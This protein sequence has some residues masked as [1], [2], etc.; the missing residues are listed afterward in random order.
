LSL[1]TAGAM[2]TENNVTPET[3]AWLRQDGRL[4]RFE[5]NI[6]ANFSNEVMAIFPPCMTRRLRHIMSQL[7]G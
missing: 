6:G 5:A 7:P 3:A 4:T 2:V 1:A